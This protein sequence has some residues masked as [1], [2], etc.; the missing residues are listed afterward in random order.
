MI[1]TQEFILLDLIDSVKDKNQQR[2]LIEQVLAASREK[3]LEP[4]VAAVVNPALTEVL[5]R[6]KKYKPL[7][8]QDL[9]TEINSSEVVQLR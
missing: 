5:G 3:K 1:I 7:S 4:K 8:M 2:K 6:L 9:R